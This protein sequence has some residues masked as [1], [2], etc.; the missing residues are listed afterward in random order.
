MS[1]IGLRLG[2]FDPLGICHSIGTRRVITSAP[3]CGVQPPCSK[4][5]W[6]MG[7][8]L[9][10]GKSGIKARLMDM[11]NFRKIELPPLHLLCD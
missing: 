6:A 4:S 2:C 9:P 7:P 10:P 8:C 5:E 11:V 3:C 1:L